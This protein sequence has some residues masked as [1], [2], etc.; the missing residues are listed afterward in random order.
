VPKS[1]FSR[2]STANF[3]SLLRRLTEDWRCHRVIAF[4]LEFV[5]K[6]DTFATSLHEK[7][8]K[9]GKRIGIS[10]SDQL[11]EKVAQVSSMLGVSESAAAR[12]LMM[13]GLE[14]FMHL[15]SSN[16]SA[17]MMKNMFDAFERDLGSG[18]AETKRK[19]GR[20]QSIQPDTVT[21]GWRPQNDRP[22]GRKT[23]D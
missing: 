17:Q 2:H 19:K 12:H 10:V 16:E 22:R 6:C 4:T 13:R 14:S 9:V 1:P 8:E 15:L 21:Q 18:G 20:V 23:H 3:P 5:Q 7:G 11:A